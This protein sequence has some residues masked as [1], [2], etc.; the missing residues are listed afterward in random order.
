MWTSTSALCNAVVWFNQP[1]SKRERVPQATANNESS[2]K[3][4]E[5]AGQTNKQTYAAS[6]LGNAASIPFN[7]LLLRAMLSLPPTQFVISHSA[8][9]IAILW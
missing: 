5:V 3:M 1:D 9:R 4:Q 7:S 2:N 6:Q 8:L